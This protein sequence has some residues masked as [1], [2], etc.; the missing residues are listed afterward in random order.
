[1]SSTWKPALESQFAAALDMLENAIR[2]CPDDVW[3]DAALDV[4]QRYWY[5]AYHTLFWLDFYLSDREQGFWPPAPFTLGELDPAGV[6]PERAFTRDELLG[7]LGHGREKLRHALGWLTDAR[8][9]ERCGFDRHEMSVLEM[10]FY[11][12]R[13]VQHH[14]AQLN[15]V[16]RQR[17]ASAPAWVGRGKV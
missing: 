4:A 2:A 12:M 8:A 5:L 10:H 13:H 6:Y 16:L 9:V 3:D 1:M 14:T 11:N 15:L 17:T 7:Y